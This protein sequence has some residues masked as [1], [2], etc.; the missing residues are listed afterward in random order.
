MT[1][2][3]YIYG[4]TSS[5]ILLLIL[6][7]FFTNKQTPK[8]V[9]KIETHHQTESNA[10]TTQRDERMSYFFPLTAIRAWSQS[11][12]LKVRTACCLSLSFQGISSDY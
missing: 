6:N 5:F 12:R 2:L 7:N 10:P 1:R 8:V 9:S 11:A 3:K 4:G